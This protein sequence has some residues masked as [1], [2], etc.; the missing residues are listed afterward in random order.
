MTLG[1][2]SIRNLLYFLTIHKVSVRGQGQCS[3]ETTSRKHLL[4]CLMY[5]CVCVLVSEVHF[6]PH[7]LFECHFEMI[8]GNVIL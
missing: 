8:S 1:K 4:F 7:A 6:L 2:D 5:E 3:Q